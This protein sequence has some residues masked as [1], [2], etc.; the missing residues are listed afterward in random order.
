MEPSR[1]FVVPL[2]IIELEEPVDDP[3]LF[4]VKSAH[5][6]DVNDG[7]SL[8]RLLEGV[9]SWA[10]ALWSLQHGL[11]LGALRDAYACVLHVCAGVGSKLLRRGGI[12][13]FAENESF[14]VLYSFVRCVPCTRTRA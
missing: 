7:A 10:T 11:N 4:R 12:E 6:L 5:R 3:N 2:T 1:R 9:R 14:D 13:N 8:Q